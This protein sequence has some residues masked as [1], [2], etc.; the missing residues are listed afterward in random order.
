MSPFEF[1][2]LFLSFIYSLALTHLLFAWTRM[3]R[4]RRQLVISWPHL[5]WMLVALFNLADDWISL[6]DF[7]DLAAL[8]LA[9]IASAL[10]FGV[11][12]YAL[13]ALVSPDFEA[14]ETYDLKDFHAREGQTYMLAYLVMILSS[15]AFNFLAGA[16]LGVDKWGN[17]NTLVVLQVPPVLLGLAVKRTWAQ[18]L[19]PA[20]LLALTISYAVV[21]YPVLAR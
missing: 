16:E 21:Y 4:H 5:L 1:I 12:N 6:W 8:S 14:G 3:I 10:L 11:V 19:A 9:T 13:C 2:I 15:I 7:R 18:L 20:L 17:E